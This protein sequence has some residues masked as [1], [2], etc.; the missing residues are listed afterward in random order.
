[1]FAVHGR[2]PQNVNGVTK[3]TALNDQNFRDEIFIAVMGRS[4]AGKSSF[5]NLASNSSLKIGEGL[6]SCTE[7]VEMSEPFQLE[8]NGRHIRL[9][10][11]P[12]FDDSFKS[13]ADI[14][15]TIATFL[16]DEYKEKKRKLSGIIYF[17]R[18]SDVRMGASSRRNF[19]MFQK[20]CGPAFL[21]NVVLAT[22]RWSEVNPAVG[23]AR[24]NELKTKAAF[25]KSIIDMGSPVMRY[26]NSFESA[27]NILGHLVGKTPLPLL[28]QREIAEELK[29]V[30]ET[31]A[32]LELHREILEQA[33]R[34]EE[35]M[36]VLLEEIDELEKEHDEI[37]TKNLDTEVR[38][39]RDRMMR[40][41]EEAHT[42]SGNKDRESMS[43]VAPEPLPHNVS[44]V[45]NAK[46][47]LE[48]LPDREG[49][50]ITKNVQSA[51]AVNV[52][53]ACL[54]A[55]TPC[56]LSPSTTTQ[57][58]DSAV[59]QGVILTPV[60]SLSRQ[61]INNAAK[62]P[63]LSTPLAETTNTI[64]CPLEISPLPIDTLAPTLIDGMNPLA[65]RLEENDH[66]AQWS[67][68]PL[69][70]DGVNPSDHPSMNER[71]EESMIPPRHPKT[72]HLTIPPATHTN[73]VEHQLETP[74]NEAVEV[75]WRKLEAL[76]V[77]VED[78]DEAHHR[79]VEA[80]KDRAEA[81]QR[82]VEKLSETVKAMET[83][84]AA[85]RI[86]RDGISKVNSNLIR[87]PPTA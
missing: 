55:T 76:Q 23:E 56:L 15:N 52:I 40:L 25:F 63:Q 62:S 31:A 87:G 59:V 1:M 21:A 75:L 38:E 39:L 77:H 12:G 32:G 29:T 58:Q 83:E 13:D 73:G 11:T 6:E 28:I 16:V 49:E 37:G 9:I 2:E 20:L 81:Y 60:R 72:L 19:V 79:D 45:E 30:S 27:R 50:D 35:E 14:L 26:E 22:T 36:C 17:H 44:D 7:S 70:A 8:P 67:S 43:P 78:R 82:E 53:A 48:Q 68:L 54:P 5:I 42:L 4:G 66:E 10:D 69:V 80:L 57:Q 24:E 71:Y 84:R 85:F 34:H 61:C 41:Q 18:I 65:R 74:G 3:E 46:R 86:E 47:T 33:K 64:D 51:V